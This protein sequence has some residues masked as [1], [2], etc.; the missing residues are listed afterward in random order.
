M[1]NELCD[2]AHD[3]AVLKGFYE[4]NRELPELLMLVVSELSE[5]MEVDR[6]PEAQGSMALLND[7]ARGYAYKDNWDDSATA[8]NYRCDIRGTVPEEI[9]D[10]FIRLFDLCGYL[11]IDIDAHVTAKMKYNATR[12]PK[13]GKRY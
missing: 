8:E 9:A 7:W 12:P 4:R 3:N 6:R 10:A 13:H 5:A 2:A 1:L 11:G